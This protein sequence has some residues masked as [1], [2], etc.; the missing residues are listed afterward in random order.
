MT[1]YLD[2][3]VNQKEF[4]ITAELVPPRHW[5]P[6]SI[7]EKAVLFRGYVDAVDISDNLL[8]V[9]R[10]SPAV[11]AFFIKQIGVEPIVQINLRDRNRLGIQSDLLGLAALG[12]SSD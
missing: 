3:Q 7:I 11:C 1:I 4:T 8:A 6:R 2:K 5:N 10:M 12:I 9:A